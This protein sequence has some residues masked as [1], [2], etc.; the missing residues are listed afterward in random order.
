MQ[1]YYSMKEGELVNFSEQQLVDCCKE[2]CYGC[3]GGYPYAAI[4]YLSVDGIQTLENYPYKEVVQKCKIKS[5]S[6]T[7]KLISTEEPYNSVYGV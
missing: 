7:I 4:Q 1:A 3:V 6:N 5:T 2:Q